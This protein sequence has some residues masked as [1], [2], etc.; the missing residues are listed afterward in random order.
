MVTNAYWANSEKRAEEIAETPRLW[1]RRVNISIDTSTSP[2]LTLKRQAGF[3]AASSSTSG[4]DHRPLQGAEHQVNDK[5]LDELLGVSLKRIYTGRRAEAG[6]MRPP[7]DGQ[8]YVAVAN[9]SLQ[10]IGRGVIELRPEDVNFE[11][12]E[13][14]LT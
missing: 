7:P 2:S 11:E 12:L 4:R 3:W 8:P 10:F 1:P 13:R 9:N 14:P 5:E 6:I